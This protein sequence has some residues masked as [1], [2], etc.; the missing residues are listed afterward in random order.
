MLDD[1]WFIPVQAAVAYSAYLGYP[2]YGELLAGLGLQTRAVPGERL[3]AFGQLMAGTNV[4]GPAVKASAG[5]RYTLS[6]R[7]A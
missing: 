7:L 2:G 4:H 3:Q 5:L 6:D 1:R